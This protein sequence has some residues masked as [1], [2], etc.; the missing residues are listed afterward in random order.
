MSTTN[1]QY[2]D[3]IRKNSLNICFLSY[4]QNYV[5]TKKKQDQISHVNEPSVFKLLRFD[6]IFLILK[7]HLL[8]VLI[9][10]TSMVFIKTS[11]VG[12]HQKH[13]TEALLM[14]TTTDVVK[15]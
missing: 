3:E 13:L 15:M 2:H 12:K 14:S 9:R 6:C 1:T 11:V 8:W 10:G 4:W 5:G 7:K